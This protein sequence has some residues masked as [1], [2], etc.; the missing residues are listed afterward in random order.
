ML[1]PGVL[2]LSAVNVL[3]AIIDL[4]KEELLVK[5]PV[6][7]PEFASVPRTRRVLFN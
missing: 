6:E 5:K 7:E 4:E 2:D 3:H 1:E